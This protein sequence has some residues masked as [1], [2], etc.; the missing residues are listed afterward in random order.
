MRAI[1]VLVVASLLV[2]ALSPA[3]AS[4]KSA[5]L[6]P[7]PFTSGG[8]VTD[9]GVGFTID[10]SDAT[11]VKFTSQTSL[12]ATRDGV[13]WVPFDAKPS[14]DQGG[15]RL[16]QKGGVGGVPFDDFF[17]P[18]VQRR[19]LFRN[20]DGRSTELD[21]ARV[22]DFVLI[23]SSNRA[24]KALVKGPSSSHA[25]QHLDALA[26]GSVTIKLKNG[27]SAEP[28]FDAV[29]ALTTDEPPD[30]ANDQFVQLVAVNTADSSTY[31][32]S[33][34]D[35][36]KGELMFHHFDLPAGSYTID[37]LDSLSLGN[38]AVSSTNVLVRSDDIARIDV[39]ANNR[40]F[41]ASLPSLALPI[42][43][44][45]T[46]TVTGL[47]GFEPSF[48]DPVT[49]D[50]ILESGDGTSRVS[51]HLTI[52]DTNPIAIPFR[53]PA[54][55]YQLTVA[56]SRSDDS[57]NSAGSS[58]IF[59]LG[60]V[61]VEGDL[62]AAIPPLVQLSGT[63]LDPGFTLAS[64]PDPAS[65]ETPAQYLL[66]SDASGSNGFSA[67][68]TLFGFV[69]SYH[70]YVPRGSTVDVSALLTAALGKPIPTSRSSENDLGFLMLPSVSDPMPCDDGCELDITTPTLPKYVTITGTLVDSRGRP[71]PLVVVTASFSGVGGVEDA[72]FEAEVLTNAKGEFHLRLPR[73][74]GYEISAYRY[75]F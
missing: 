8:V 44:D 14:I 60:T 21:V 46:L 40:L 33:A 26:D 52:D 51:S 67:S 20:G 56:A 12:S 22:N 65:G 49:L 24:P 27:P 66:V 42:L 58:T 75:L 19:L 45:A 4:A 57:A 36:A 50:V 43:V 2:P 1:V 69:R 64:A 38:P 63:V 48:G 25:D 31:Y 34:S 13:T 62:T 35:F 29:V 7:G 55:E 72:S 74:R 10:T 53:A 47:D 73:G 6:G 39:S 30:G 11:A 54:G 59:K 32:S 23:L 28:S 61:Q 68:A 9:A 37:A 3:P 17:P 5:K 15:T 70:V 16:T 18:N 71:V 41:A